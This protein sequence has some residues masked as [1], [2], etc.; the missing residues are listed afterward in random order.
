MSDDLN[1][2]HVAIIPDG[3][4]RWAK[5]HALKPW[6]GHDAGARQFRPILKAALRE[7]VYCVSAWLASVSNLTNRSKVEVEFL[8][9]VLESFFLELQDMPEVEE[10]GVRVQALGDWKK[11]QPPA[12]IAAIEGAMEKTK[13]HTNHVLNLF[14][15]YDGISEMTDA[16][17]A[18]VEQGR[19]DSSFA[20]D[21]AAIKRNLLTADLPPVDLV[22]RTG[23]EPHWSGGFMMWDIAE[24]QFHFSQKMFPDFGEADFLA[25]LE[26]YRSRERRHGK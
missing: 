16:I 23:G 1:P 26:D 22:I 12:L 6:E 19:R 13:H 17:Q 18:M 4:R 8:Y 21:G 25:A 9:K 24:A 2:R 5:A 3:N 11:Y 14:D 20:V 7:G 10:Y 15:A